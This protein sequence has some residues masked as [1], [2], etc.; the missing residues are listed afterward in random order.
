[1]L[2]IRGSMK[3]GKNLYTIFIDGKKLVGLPNEGHAIIVTM[4]LAKARG[5]A[6]ITYDDW[7]SSIWFHS[8][9]KQHNA[10]V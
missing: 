3:H 5:I 6:G 2:E 7:E 4:A 10:E 9:G 1:M 8:N